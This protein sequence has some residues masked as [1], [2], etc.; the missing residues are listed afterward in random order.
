MGKFRDHNF[1]IADSLDFFD[2]KSPRFFMAGQISCLGNIVIDVAKELEWLDDPTVSNPRVQTR[3]YS[4]HVSVRNV[5]P[6]FRYDNQH[7]DHLH[8]GHKDEHH[9]DRPKNNFGFC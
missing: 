5:A 8:P 3:M 1:V 9:K 2:L 4:Y 6:I 7:A